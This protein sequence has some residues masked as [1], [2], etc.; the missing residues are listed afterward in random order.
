[1]K[2]RA[3]NNRKESLREEIKSRKKTDQTTGSCPLP[4]Q[5]WQREILRIAIQPPLN[6]PYLRKA[7]IAYWEQVG[8]NRHFG[9][10][11]G[12]ITH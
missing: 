6:T 3:G 1:M 10:S 8:V 12:D 11:Q 7:S 2:R 5:G 9:P 4:P